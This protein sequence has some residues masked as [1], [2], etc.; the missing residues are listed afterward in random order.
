MPTFRGGLNREDFNLTNVQI[1]LNLYPS[2]GELKIS[3]TSSAHVD[4]KF[5]QS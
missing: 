2:M 3:L 4:R 1:I 5:M